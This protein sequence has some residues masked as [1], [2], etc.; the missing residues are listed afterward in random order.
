MLVI[1]KSKGL[2]TAVP[3]PAACAMNK[4]LLEQRPA[5]PSTYGLWLL[6]SQEGGTR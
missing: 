2:Q 4:A 5:H 3:A 6:L 1:I